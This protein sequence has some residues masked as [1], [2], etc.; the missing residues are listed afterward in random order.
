MGPP[1]TRKDAKMKR[2][3]NDLIFKDETY[4][5]MGA[6]FQVYQDKGCGFLEAVYQECLEIEF[7]FLKIPAVPKQ[8]L[9]LSYRGRKLRQQYEPDFICYGKIIVELKAASDLMD[10]HRAQVINYLNATG[11]QLG[12]LINFG[13]HPRV[14]WERLAHSKARAR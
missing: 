12:L 7:D 3:V 4:S 6:C 9:T 1:N 2:F 14:E 11:Y 5:I 10:E 13:H 8:P